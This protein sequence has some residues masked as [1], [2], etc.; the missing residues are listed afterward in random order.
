MCNPQLIHVGTALHP[1]LTV[2]AKWDT[3][4][5][6]IQNFADAI[7]SLRFDYQQNKNRSTNIIVPVSLLAWGC[8]V[9]DTKSQNIPE[10]VVD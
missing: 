10:V 8:S 7:F 1:A 9:L 4:A 2:K 3:F 6:P 5:V